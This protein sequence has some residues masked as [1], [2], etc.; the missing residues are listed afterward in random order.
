M[1]L[2]LNL[3]IARSLGKDLDCLN[4]FVNNGNHSLFLLGNEQ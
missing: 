3:L 2:L 4:F 1:F